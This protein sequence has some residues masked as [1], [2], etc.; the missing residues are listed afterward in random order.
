MAALTVTRPGAQLSFRRARRSRHGW[1]RARPPANRPGPRVTNP[2]AWGTKEGD[3]SVEEGR[4]EGRAAGLPVVGD[5]RHADLL[6]GRGLPHFRSEDDMPSSLLRCSSCG[7]VLALH[8]GTPPPATCAQCGVPLEQTV[9]PPPQTEVY[10][11]KSSFLAE[12]FVVPLEIEG[13]RLLG[14]LGRGGMGVVYRALGSSVSTVNAASKGSL[15]GLGGGR[16]RPPG[17]LP[18]R[19]R[20][21]RLPQRLA[22]PA[23]PRRPRFGR[24]PHPGSCRSSTAPPSWASSTRR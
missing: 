3:H 17:T 10:E 11:A 16:P 13:Y 5:T 20:P 18:P 1:P 15:P 14:I 21:G 8:E 23:D 19:G 24:R 6:R 9:V 12:T 7:S 2:D 22:H 4:R